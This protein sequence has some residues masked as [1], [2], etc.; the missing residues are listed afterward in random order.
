MNLTTPGLRPIAGVAVALALTVAAAGCGSD[1][2]SAAKPTNDAGDTVAGG[3]A[4]GKQ[5]TATGTL[6]AEGQDSDGTSITVSAVNIDGSP[7]W[8]AV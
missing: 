5:A 4:K 8:I 6:M 1:S 7:G 2:D 3:T